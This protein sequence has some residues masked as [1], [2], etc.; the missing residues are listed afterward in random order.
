MSPDVENIA[1]CVKIGNKCLYLTCSYPFKNVDISTY[2]KRGDLT[3]NL[4][5][6]LLCSCV[7]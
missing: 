2:K 6:F 5:T 7:F 3:C 1:T 4:R